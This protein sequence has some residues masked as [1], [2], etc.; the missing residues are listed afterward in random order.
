ME[1][2]REPRQ[3]EDLPVRVFGVD[4]QGRIFD[5][6]VLA[7]NISQS[8]ALLVGTDRKLRCGDLMVVQFGA[9]NARFRIVWVR[10]SQAAVQRLQQDECPWLEILAGRQDDSAAG[11]MRS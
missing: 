4:E 6:S 10:D 5:E 7:H 3:I 2:R 1:R 9:L 8:G 11:K